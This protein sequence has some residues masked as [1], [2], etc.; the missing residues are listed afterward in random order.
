MRK[1]LRGIGL[2]LIA[3]GVCFQAFATSIEWG[4]TRTVT[5]D[6]DA[7]A[8][9]LIGETSSFNALNITNGGSVADDEGVIG[10]D[11]GTF[12]NRVL[13]S[14]EGSV[15]TNRG[16]LHIGDNGS[17]SSLQIADGA[18][19]YSAS[20]TLGVEAHSVSNTVVVSGSNTVW[21][22]SNTLR[23]G[24]K[25]NLN[26][27][28]IE[29]GATVVNSHAY[30]GAEAPADQN[31]VEVSGAGSVWSNR[32][33]LVIGHEVPGDNTLVIANQGKV[34]V[35]DQLVI[36]DEL[37]LNDGGWLTIN[38]HAHLTRDGFN[39]NP[40]STLEVGG[41]VW[42]NGVV[43]DRNTLIFQGEDAD[44]LASGL[45]SLWVGFAGD[46]N[47]VIISNRASI[48]TGFTL[49]GDVF[50][51]T[52]NR[53]IISGEGASQ[54][55][56]WDF[57]LGDGTSSNQLLLEEGGFYSSG[58]TGYVAFAS[59]A[60]GNRLTVTGENSRLEIPTTW[61]AHWGAN[62]NRIEILD[63]GQAS[64]GKF[65]MGV[66]NAN[67]N[68]IWIEGAGSR[69]EASET[70]VSFGSR[71]NRLVLTNGAYASAGLV[72]VGVGTNDM[73]NLILV[74]GSGSV[75]EAS[76][77]TLGQPDGIPSTNNLLII[78]HGGY[79]ATGAI[80]MHNDGSNSVGNK[81]FLNEG[82][83]LTVQTDMDAQLAN[84]EWGSNS[85]L[86]VQGVFSNLAYAVN[87]VT[88][89]GAH[90]GVN[91][92]ILSGEGIW[93]NNP[94]VTVG[95]TT[96]SNN[97]YLRDGG[98]VGSSVG[99]VGDEA[100]SH[101]NR[102]EI[103]GAG[104]AWSNYNS[105][106]FGAM[107]G[108]N[109]LEV[110]DAGLL[111][112]VSVVVGENSDHNEIVVRDVGSRMEAYGVVLGEAGNSN[113]IHVV[114]GGRVSNSNSRRTAGAVIG[115]FSEGNELLIEGAGSYWFQESGLQVGGMSGRGN[116]MT[117]T[118]GGGA[119]IEENLYI[120]YGALSESNRVVIKGSAAW[121]ESGVDAHIGYEGD[122]NWLTLTD[123]ARLVSESGVVGSLSEAQQNVVVVEGDGTFWYNEHELL[124]GQSGS[125]NLVQVQNGGLLMS[126][127]S[128]LGLHT[129]SFG[130]RV[131][132]DGPETVWYSVDELSVGHNGSGNALIISNGAQVVS[133]I[134]RIGTSGSANSN[135]VQVT[136]AN[137]EW[138]IA[139]GLSVG[140]GYNQGNVLTVTNGGSVVVHDDFVIGRDNNVYLRNGGS[141]TV[142]G[143]TE[144][145]EGFSL[146]EGASFNAL[147]SI[148]G[149]G[150]YIEQGRTVSIA[151]EN[152]R[153]DLDESIFL[154]SGAMLNIGGGARVYTPSNYTQ[155]A[156]ATLRFGMSTNSSGEMISGFLDVGMT[157]DL[158]AGSSFLYAGDIARLL[159]DQPYTNLLLS[160]DTLVIGGQTNAAL[161]DLENALDTQGTLSQV[162][163]VVEDDEIYAIVNRIG[164][165]EAIRTDEET[166][167]GFSSLLE[168]I[169]IL[170][171]EGNA[172]G[173]NQLMLINE[174]TPE[175]AD[176]ALTQ[177]YARGTP[178]YMH[179][180]GALD[181][182]RQISRRTSE[183]LVDTAFY[184]DGAAGPAASGETRG[185]I[186][187]FGGRMTRDAASGLSD[188]DLT[189]YGT[190]VGM[191][192]M[193]E[194]LTLGV[195]GGLTGTSIDQDDG[196][197]SDAT[198]AYG[199]VYASK[200]VEGIDLDLVGSFGFSSIENESGT[201]F[202]TDA[203]TEATV[204]AL[205]GALSEEQ[206]YGPFTFAFVA[207]L[208]A[209]SY[210]QSAYD[211][212][213]SVAI[214][215]E[216][217]NYDRWSVESTL[218]GTLGATH[219]FKNFDLIT[220][221]NMGWRHEFNS[222]PDELDFRLEGGLRRHTFEVDAPSS[223]IVDLGVDISA[224][225]KE[226]LEVGVGLE[227]RIAQEFSALN[228]NAKVQ[229]SF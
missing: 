20:G 38:G 95:Y 172:A 40:G 81:I 145:S 202:G 127:R 63:G 65:W 79:V 225:F 72:G 125:S 216:V 211:E 206:S 173:I 29:D 39:Y 121:L 132:I 152:S 44:W 30:I 61:F 77:I 18:H 209:A 22:N 115:D 12:D 101:D 108:T 89:V 104:S 208:Q 227:G 53:L 163:F 188:F 139:N 175:E 91:T 210:R 153:W 60:Y 17:Y 215:L 177:L 229:Y 146:D 106:V 107:G 19:V 46:D 181:G 36:Y 26:Y 10:L 50:G 52:G 117:I 159:F 144:F 48:D 182:V 66:S 25:G 64:L 223:D 168:E 226:R 207:G 191:D 73:D 116:L 141:L 183:K 204:V 178:A 27:L 109:Q 35:E 185:W 78:E 9:L 13:V 11:S 228:Y 6:W 1:C 170:A 55:T 76:G 140:N 33:D 133:G 194:E 7:G 221:L 129:N 218:G 156:G 100:E 62:S 70:V 126:P 169:E 5:N 200:Q 47:T 166:Q 23:V 49:V 157:A 59:G 74:T 224:L 103:S 171:N 82:G 105:L 160:A 165:D 54:K 8:S 67:D 88:N 113:R 32:G 42:F 180:G 80:E 142:Y 205:Y 192:R 57:W 197:R 184:I 189:T 94:M 128:V 99:I 3:A 135:L 164:V 212:T 222:D 14:G 16:L 193:Y 56:T 58:R 174:L 68:T 147:G 119:Y 186:S 98:I 45:Q 112:A 195:A 150:G 176:E 198:T 190:I 161:A 217:D 43:S 123:G 24:H 83:W 124:V 34:V 201:I 136:G 196:D 199:A 41:E 28:L 118:N 114:N 92:L 110:S 120:G 154:E 93:T 213:S 220:Q 214:G 71:N 75:L 31:L 179:M 158:A 2:L 187:T 137:S 51:S 134:S 69:L 130:N 138:I 37:D 155:Q 97:M 219:M 143:D 87:G 21:G 102:I 162:S 131:V 15:W 151:G 86:E 90:S 203:E 149:L 111:Y 167:A 96:S 4:I 85:T 122:R 148:V 84:F